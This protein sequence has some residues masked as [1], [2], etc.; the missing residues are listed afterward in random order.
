[1]IGEV[2]LVV[3][4]TS[5]E[6]VGERGLRAR[7]RS[8]ARTPGCGR[9]GSPTCAT[10]DSWMPSETAS[11]QRRAEVLG[12]QALVVEAVAGLVEDAEERVAEVLLVVAG[13]DA[14]VAG[15]DAGAERVDGDVE[16]AGV[17]VEA[18]GARRP[19]CRVS[20]GRRRDSC[21]RGSRRALFGRTSTIRPT[22]STSGARSAAKTRSTVLGGLAGLEV[23]EQGVVAASAGVAEAVG[24]LPLE[25][26]ASSRARA[27]RGEVVLLA[28]PRPRRAGRGPRSWPSPRPAT[29]GS[30]VARSYARRVSRTLTAASDSGSLTRSEDSTWA[31]RSPI[32]GR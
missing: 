7:G 9:R 25:V 13:G 21:A 31:S 10:G 29:V 32:S 4:S 5:C 30:L 19:R 3:A 23:V 12:G 28:R 22:R 11:P 2:P 8:A 14:G 26:Q 15:A 6:A 17:E 27:E 1:M 24:L 18:D 16:P 20:P